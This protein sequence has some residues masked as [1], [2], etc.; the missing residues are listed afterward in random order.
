MKLLKSLCGLLFCT[1]VM[2]IALLVSVSAT[3]VSDTPLTGGD[4]SNNLATTITATKP[5]ENEAEDFTAVIEMEEDK[6]SEF[7]THPT[8]DTQRTEDVD[9]SAPT[10]DETPLPPEQSLVIDRPTYLPI[11][12]YLE[13]EETTYT[14]LQIK[15]G[16]MPYLLYV[17]STAN[18]YDSL[19]LVV[20]LHGS[21]ERG[22]STSY[23]QKVSLPKV[24]SE[25]TLKNPD[26]YIVCPILKNESNWMD[27][28]SVN[29]VSSIID[30]ICSE[31]NINVERISLTGAS[32]GGIGSLYIG[33]ELND[34]LYRIAT[35][36]GYA[37][38]NCIKKITVPI[39]GFVGH[40][41]YGEDPR[42][43]EYMT[44]TFYR[45]FGNVS[46]KVMNSSHGGLPN[47]VF[48]ID[49]NY[50]GYSDIFMW[51]IGE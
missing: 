34:R 35:F 24:L 44:K 39:V 11:I 50:D 42:S 25:W 47:D 6:Q 41:S 28:R 3:S 20:W 37:C 31:Y 27:R 38:G 14:I 51:L 45:E 23:Y 46:T 10:G 13:N 21:G 32:L 1:L 5:S 12:D 4:S 36:S 29:H 49:E 16:D 19:P 7:S 2:L 30:S 26:A 43:Y 33:G 48:T 15:N 18:K 17:P 40:P 22:S 8:S 9:D